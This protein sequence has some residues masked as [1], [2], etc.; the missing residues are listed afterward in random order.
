VTLQETL[1]GAPTITTTTA[2]TMGTINS[3][4]AA[5]GALAVPLPALSSLNV[6]ASC[7]VEKNAEDSS[8]NTITFTCSGSDTFDDT[9]TTLVLHYT[10][11]KRT[12]QVVFI[13]GV[14]YWKI[15]QVS[16]GGALPPLS[17]LVPWS[18]GTAG[19]LPAT[20]GQHL[21][22]QGGNT[23]DDG[24]GNV[25]IKG[26]T[27]DGVTIGGTTAATSITT[28]RLLGPASI[29]LGPSN[30]TG[31]CIYE[32][33]ILSGTATG[34]GACANYLGFADQI[35][36]T[37]GT[38]YTGLMLL[39]YVVS[40]AAGGRIGIWG[41][42]VVDSVGSGGGSGFIGV[43]GRAITSANLGGTLAA[44]KGGLWG[45]WFTCNTGGGTYHASVFGIEVDVNCMSNYILQKIGVRIVLG[46]G[47]TADDTVRGAL[48]DTALNIMQ[49]AGATSWGIGV[50]FGTDQSSTPAT[51]SGY[52]PFNNT[53]T[54]IGTS[55]V[56]DGLPA[57]IGIDFS[58]ITF[59]GPAFKTGAASIAMSEMTSAPSGISGEGQLY[60]ASD[61]SLHYLSPG[62][63]DTMM[64]PA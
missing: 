36:A 43:A 19:I 17:A 53:S 42:T 49:N 35:S 5:G 14:K 46:T 21:T 16:P 10:G 61:G 27:L 26:G 8:S 12:L 41:Q 25:V 47:D 56:G 63:T 28:D 64:A 32:S 59:S 57:N 45:G 33:I 54:I 3:Y 22:T 7:I 6:N 18:G 60:V 50:K 52:W 40:P 20:S 51:I 62:G 2:P 30:Q 55:A 44:P 38:G 31:A 15:I 34:T 9:T 1:N 13:S 23:L 48:D 11:E 24:S 4:S 37:V 58:L 39:D 29:A